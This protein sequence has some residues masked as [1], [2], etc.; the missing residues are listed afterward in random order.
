MKIAT[1]RGSGKTKV[2]KVGYESR[3]E[4]YSLSKAKTYLGRLVEKAVKGETV[5]ILRG[6]QRFV[7][8][9]MPEI[10]PIPQRPPGYFA[11][12][13]AKEELQLENRLAEA[14]VIEKP[15]DLE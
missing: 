2:P 15:G 11:D 10:A 5:Y 7:L 4:T 13:Y 1:H 14:S 9:Y 6:T 12:C 8:Q 3:S